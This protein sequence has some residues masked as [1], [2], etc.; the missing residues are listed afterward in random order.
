M[1]IQPIK[2]GNQPNVARFA[3]AALAAIAQIPPAWPLDHTV[4]VN[5]FL[6]QADRSFADTAALLRD[7]A[8]CRIAMPRAWFRALFDQGELTLADLDAALGLAPAPHQDLTAAQLVAALAAEPEP[9]IA[10]PTIADLAASVSGI[11]WPAIIA[12]RIGSWAAAY[13]DHGQA[14][15][16]A[17]WAAA[18]GDAFAAWRDHARHDLTPELLGLPGF[19]AFVNAMP[20]NAADALGMA[21]ELIALPL[22]AADRYYHRLLMT[23]GGWSHWARYRLWQA[24]LEGG[25][26]ATALGLLA[27]RQIW[28]AALVLHY[29]PALSDPWSAAV[30]AYAAPQAPGI[31]DQIDAILH[32]AADLAAQRRLAATLAAPITQP[33]AQAPVAQAVFCIDVR[34]E[35][36][37]RALET[38]DPAIRTLGFAGFFGIGTAHRGFGSDVVEA[39]LPVLLAPGV[40]SQ[41]AGW[42]GKA[43]GDARIRARLVRAWGRF[44]LAAVSS[45]A[46]VEAAG[47]GYVGKLGK[48]ALRLGGH[49]E[50]DDPMPV[51]QPSLSIGER[52]DAAERALRGMSL[53]TDFAPLVLLIGHGAQVA[54][55]PHAS[56]LQCGACGGHAGDVN[57]RLL[58]ALLNAADVRAALAPRGIAIPHTTRFVA[59]LHDTTS[60][61]VRFYVD[62]VADT[63]RMTPQLA[64]IEAAFAKAGALARGER[65]LTLP[66]AVAGRSPARR[67]RDW[68][69][70]RPEWGLA[71]C[72]AF[73]AAPR[74]LTQGRDLGGRVFLHDYDWRADQGFAVLELI[75]TAPVVVASWISLQYYGSS[76]APEL[77]GA[78]NKLLH[79]VI[80]GLGVVE[81]N[82]GLLRAGL[83]WQSVHDGEALRHSPQRLTVCIAA[84]SGAIGDVLAA[85]P[86]VRA[87]FDNHWLHLV[88]LD[89]AGRFAA[90]YVGN[91]AWQSPAAAA[92]AA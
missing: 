49:A 25:T 17:L 51:L 58:A 29:G 10:L 70:T 33:E 8:G 89:D 45:F 84:P 35:R 65:A 39:R 83:P 12:D 28:D 52:T 34:S 13:A 59:G 91:G 82:G 42:G 16:Q 88:A 26:D 53:T 46:F 73:I 55:N 9:A 86:G 4:A 27:V 90:R 60:D 36:Y 41:A 81:G 38:A 19:A 6:G 64:R 21:A 62:D 72:E 67:G 85:H 1:L 3:E 79:N 87:L 7:V 5:P 77:F 92:R 50:R 54:N 37:R 2:P 15:G 76:V 69:E 61:R 22:E 23:M 74:A 66:G 43:D 11:D 24:E 80:G 30:V 63:A 14:Q 32:L 18:G 40:T 75:L 57:A 71:G 48:D 20:A 47:L 56:A 31:D 44:K 78:G 68:S